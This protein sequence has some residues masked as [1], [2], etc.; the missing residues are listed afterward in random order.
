MVGLRA[1]TMTRILVERFL[2]NCEVPVERIVL[3]SGCLLEDMV[4]F[5]AAAGCK[6]PSDV[7][8]MNRMAGTLGPLVVVAVADRC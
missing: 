6:K 8:G 1:R 5:A 2:P 3:D 7:E 4:T